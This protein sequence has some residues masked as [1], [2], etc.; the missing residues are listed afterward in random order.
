MDRFFGFDLGDAESAVSLLSDPE[1]TVPEELT[2]AGV[3]SFVTAC[4]VTPEGGLLIGEQACYAAGVSRRALRFK[5]RFLT[6]PASASEVRSFAA[7][8]LGELYANGDL[9]RGD[10][11][12]F[13]VGCPAGWDKN[14]RE[15]YRAIFER[16]GY[17][18]ARIVSESR[19]AMVSACQSKHLQ[20]GYD[21]LS[22]PVL[23]V[24]IGSS[25][26][27][28][29]YIVGG[30]EAEMATGGEVFLGGGVM[31]EILLDESVEASRDAKEL[32]KVFAESEPWRT[33]CEFKARRL[34]E[35]YFSDEAY[36]S[37]NDCCETVV[38]RYRRPLKLT[39]RMD[40]E[41]ARA[42]LE[43]ATPHLGG[44]SFRT[45][46]TDALRQVRAQTE[47]QLPELLFLTGGVSKLPQVR[48]WCREIF[49][50]AVVIAGTEPEFSVSRGL[51]WSGRIDEELRQFR[52]E[53]EDLRVSDTVEHIVRG[54]IGA[55]YAAAVDALI[56]PVVDEVVM[57]VF[58][59]WR[60]GELSTLTDA[61]EALQKDLEGWLRT[62]GAQKRLV[63][64]IAAW[65][66]PVAEDLEEH[67]VPICVRHHVP[68]QALS[69]RSGLSAEDLD[70]RLE[71]KSLFPVG[72]ITWLIDSI[73][74]LLVGLLCGGSGLALISSG[75]VG[76][77][78]GAGASLLLLLLGKER[79]EQA[80]LA[81]NMPKPMRKL[82]PRSAFRA[83]LK[84]IARDLR[85]EL[86]VRFEKEKN[87]EISARVVGEI[88]QQIER[89]LGKMAEVVE[90]PLG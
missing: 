71:A 20:V 61:D 7:G 32:R 88:S 58:E 23:V 84:P 66:R 69:L 27:D 19:A 8:V 5:S 34:K 82:V 42:L 10:D 80:L 22:K 76:I 53:I 43:R 47:K 46:F 40:P 60:S 75:P 44:R 35:K 67:T 87:D 81:A 16:A 86:A 74:S 64:P 45:V 21:I 25:T 49:P 3:R 70:I 78:A 6:D 51:A 57:P 59:R 28:F 72:E 9:V 12:R 68:Y 55:L 18:P 79:M 83:R 15:D 48:A 4:A 39:L 52:Q 11:S 85:R 30:R 1:Q 73:V 38:V 89:C 36:W 2:V 33:Y 63:A 37:A 13:Y 50:E 90:I 56:E 29:A 14:A 31:D 24:D 17:P 65:L 26:T 41:R 62:E 54:R 77:V